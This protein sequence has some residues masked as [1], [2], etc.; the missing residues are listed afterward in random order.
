[1]RGI[2]LVLLALVSNNILA[3]D[4]ADS[5]RG[6]YVQRFPDKFFLWPVIK[7]RSLFFDISSR[8]DR[9]KLLN[10]RPN[11]AFGVGMGFYLF[12]VVV[13]LT[14]AV[15][16]NEKSRATFG[17]SDVR[18]LQINFL[19]KNWGG[20]VYSQNYSGFYVA[21]PNKLITTDDEFAKRPDIEM[22]NNGINAI[23]IL[24]HNTF[25]L[26]SAYNFS[27]RQLKSKGSFV[28]TGSLNNV[29]V[30]ADS[31]ILG[32]RYQN[33]FSVDPF[34][35][36]R[37]TTLS[38]APGYTY[39]LVYRSFF[40]NTTLALGPAHHWI[41]YKPANSSGQ[42]DM[43]I[44]TFADIRISIGY[45]GQRFFSGMSYVTK[46]RD[47]LIDDLRFTSN[48]SVFKILVGYRFKEVGILK[49]RAVDLVPLDVIH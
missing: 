19:G 2:L 30:H 18:D 49:K 41:Y 32:S 46:S 48:S 28:I 31:S 24:N 44:N 10:Y 47:I 8:T 43:A 29:R 38:M 16:L 3:Q 27:E 9:S 21:D 14:T 37:Y 36:L 33:F 20:D 17:E 23:Y 1:M 7:Q 45:N 40:L 5:L 13:E 22:V 39:S 26:R 15:P 11:N 34:H 4:Q 6:R 35:V 42:Y 12:E 25:S